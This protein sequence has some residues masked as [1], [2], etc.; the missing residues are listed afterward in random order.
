LIPDYSDHLFIGFEWLSK[1]YRDS[2]EDA[3]KNYGDWLN[4]FYYY[5]LV[6]GKDVR[7]ALDSASQATCDGRDYGETQLHLGYW[8]E[9]PLTHTYQRSRMCLWGDYSTYLPR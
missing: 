3:S 7:N 9:N 5:L 4:K 1:S 8:A 6:E 2:T